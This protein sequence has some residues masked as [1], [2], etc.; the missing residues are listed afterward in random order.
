MERFT[1]HTYGGFWWV[2]DNTTGQVVVN[3]AR[4][5]RLFHMREDEFTNRA[6]EGR[7]KRLADKLNAEGT[8]AT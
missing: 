2:R 8:A 3:K 7:A 5:R 1:A 6:A 4:A